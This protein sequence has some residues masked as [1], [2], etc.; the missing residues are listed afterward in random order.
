MLGMTVDEAQA[1]IPSSQ[2]VQWARYLELKW[3][4]RTASH[5]YLAA[6]AAAI[7]RTTTSSRK[8]IRIED[9]LLDFKGTS[10]PKAVKRK[11]TLQGSKSFWFAT[12]GLKKE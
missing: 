2:F 10:R 5:Y 1:R 11:S 4:E 12:L 3:T 8:P 9:H 6:I 7:Y